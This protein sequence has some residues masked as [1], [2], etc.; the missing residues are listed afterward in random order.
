MIQ[1]TKNI[2][3]IFILIDALGWDYIKNRPFLDN[4]A[5]TERPVK[6][7]LGFSSGV[8]PSILTGKFPEEHKHWSLYYYS[9]KTSPFRWTRSLLWL[10]KKMLNSRIARKI[11][12]EISKKIMGY[13]GYF[14]T[15]LTPVEHLHLFDICENKN[16]YAPS[17]IRGAD[18][19][20]DIL[21]NK[22]IDYKSF[23][24]PLKDREIFARA[25]KAL[26]DSDSSFYFLYLSESDANLH[27]ICRNKEQ[28]NA[29]I[30]YYEKEVYELYR[31]A[32][33]K[34]REVN[35]F[36]FSD[37]SMACVERSFNLKGEI[38]NL[39]FRMPRD[40]VVFYD[41]TM[42]R[43]WFFNP[44]AK[45]AILNFLKKKNC[46]RVL[47]K[48]ELKKFGVNFEN[49]MYGEVIFLMDTGSV[50]IPSFMGSKLPQGMH[51]FGVDDGTMDAMLISNK[52]TKED[53]KDVK[54]FFKLMLHRTKQKVKILYF[55]NSTVKAGVEEHVL[56]LVKHLDRETF[57]PILVCPQKLID[58]IRE[59]LEEIKVRFY[60]V[61]IR[62]W[63]NIKEIRKFLAILREE[64]PDIVHSHLFF[65]T[66]FAALLA[67]FTGVS[68]VIETAHIRE[69]W[70]KGI[71]KVYAIDRFFYRFVDK[72]IA[73]SD[74]VKTYLIK[75][76]KL[77]KEKTEL[78]RNGV[79]LEKF[80][81]NLKIR[82]NGKFKI[83]VIGRLEPQ[84]GHRYFLE[85]VKMLDGD[86]KDVKFLIIGEG[87]LR[88]D[89]EQRCKELK[90][91]DRVEF[92][93]FRKDIVSVLRELDLIV[94]P[95]LYEGLPLVALEAGAVG[96]PTI[97]T[98][99][100]GSPE[101]IINNKTGLVIS[102]KD[103][104]SLKEAIEKMISSEKL[105][106]EFGKNAR[107]YI[108]NNFSLK[109][110]IEKTQ[111]LYKRLVAW[112]M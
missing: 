45:N 69:A 87:G 39:K 20:F 59:N 110:Q 68:K 71:K 72:V 104:Q 13:S 88:K 75:D 83:G 92:L 52:T 54:D 21:R 64:K 56:Q 70:R 107:K 1:K 35:L 5:V 99:V 41:S 42:A 49:N 43:F 11:V 91:E 44:K 76:K 3:S 8:I 106:A 36:V 37:H 28:V 18:S 22:N 10:P 60:P 40:Y 31:N 26:G 48:E 82:N 30:D 90:I 25:K 34:F 109:Q 97:V 16:I 81:P 23:T 100:D 51:G 24:Y 63:R 103:S 50:I 57:D 61:H 101:V 15:Y 47:T 14:E 77:S 67:K 6:S 89:L 112:K 62:R 94:L 27:S 84:K 4:I 96:K 9:P 95:S 98:N 32:Q 86:S 7:I 53:I 102:S 29:I 78:I 33:K 38:E 55:L 19:I 12:E 73:V 58:L 111:N 2:V 93:G 108:K 66:R 65:A 17:G 79:D 85:A 105:V 80:K 74:A 46:G